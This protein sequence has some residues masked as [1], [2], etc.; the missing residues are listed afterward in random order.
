[1]PKLS[2]EFLLRTARFYGKDSGV[3]W[4]RRYGPVHSDLNSAPKTCCA[5]M[6]IVYLHEL[7]EIPPSCTVVTI[8]IV[9]E[10]CGLCDEALNYGTFQAIFKAMSISLQVLPSLIRPYQLQLFTLSNCHKPSKV[11]RFQDRAIF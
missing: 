11:K 3:L 2:T 8:L 4:G 1:M 5:R 9:E 6:R 7:R 10:W